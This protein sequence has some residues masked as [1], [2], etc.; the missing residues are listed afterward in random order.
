MAESLNKK[1]QRAILKAIE[2]IAN[3]CTEQ[4][5]AEYLQKK[6]DAANNLSQ[7]LSN[8]KNISDVF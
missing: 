1:A 2:S 3:N 5:A 6:A 4:Q 7:A 8:M